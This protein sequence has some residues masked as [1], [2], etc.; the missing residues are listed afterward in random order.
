MSNRKQ[1]KSKQQK[2]RQTSSDPYPKNLSSIL[3]PFASSM[4]LNNGHC[5]RDFRSA[6]KENTQ[7]FPTIEKISTL[8]HPSSVRPFVHLP[9]LRCKHINNPFHPLKNQVTFRKNKPRITTSFNPSSSNLK[10]RANKRKNTETV[11]T[12]QGDIHDKLSLLP[13]L[14]S[15]SFFYTGPTLL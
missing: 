13:N 10:F 8:D 11:D 7:L 5:K 1:R 6:H 12:A 2:L 9:L 3:Q 14:L 15:S 4:L